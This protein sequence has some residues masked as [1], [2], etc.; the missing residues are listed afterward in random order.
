MQQVRQR[1]PL[2]QELT[3]KQMMFLMQRAEAFRILRCVPVAG[4]DI[5]FLITVQ[6][7][8]GLNLHLPASLGPPLV[9]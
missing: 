4:F 7:S 2:E 9:S 8:L 1:D 5:S 3:A 6:V